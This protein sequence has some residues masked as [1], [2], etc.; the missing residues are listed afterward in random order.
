[1]NYIEHGGWSFPD[2]DIEQSNEDGSLKNDGEI[3]AQINQSECE[4]SILS[5]VN[6]SCDQPSISTQSIHHPTVDIHHSTSN[7]TDAQVEFSSTALNSN[8]LSEAI[9]TQ[10]EFANQ[11]AASTQ[12]NID[13][14]LAVSTQTDFDNQYAASTQTDFDNQRPISTQTDFVNQCTASTQTDLD[15]LRAASDLTLYK[16][17][18]VTATV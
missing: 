2:L 13:N 12:E 15:N 3:N 4:K 7:E 5:N 17:E 6:V 14:T 9:P 1:M 18:P 16:A 10:S 8:T 11:C